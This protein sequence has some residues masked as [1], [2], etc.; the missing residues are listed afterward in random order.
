MAT[1]SGNTT[2]KLGA[3]V[4]E[5]GSTSTSEDCYDVPAGK[6]GVF[7]GGCS[8]G[9][10]GYF[11]V[12]GSRVATVG[13]AGTGIFLASDGASIRF[14]ATSGTPDWDLHGFVLENSPA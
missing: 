9:Q 4:N 11:T 8:A 2:L 12:D 6:A 3:V 14:V 5:Q 1:Y 7:W 10:A 13:G